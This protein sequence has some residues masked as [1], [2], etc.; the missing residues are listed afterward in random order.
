MI[1]N[2]LNVPNL[3][4]ISHHFIP[5]RTQHHNH[6]DLTN[7]ISLN[8]NHARYRQQ[9][10]TLGYMNQRAGHL[11]IYDP[12]FSILTLEK[13]KYENASWLKIPPQKL[14]YRPYKLINK[15]NKPYFQI[16]VYQ[17]HQFRSPTPVFH[18]L[19]KLIIKLNKPSNNHQNITTNSDMSDGIM[20]GM[21]FFQGSYAG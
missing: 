15:H 21:R 5:F 10:K 11:G 12:N 13:T 20:K 4:V 17:I 7:G 2:E 8:H 14:L 9:R 19:E 18:E 3:S 1:S 6:N 16:L